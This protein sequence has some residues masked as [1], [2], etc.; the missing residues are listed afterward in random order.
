MPDF[1]RSTVDALK[2][3]SRPVLGRGVPAG[4]LQ[5]LID[6]GIT[7]REIADK[8]ETLLS[9][10][11]LPAELLAF[12][13]SWRLLTTRKGLP[14]NTSVPNPRRPR[15]CPGRRAR[16]Q[17]AARYARAARWWASP[18]PLARGGPARARA[19]HGHRQPEASGPLKAGAN[20][21]PTRAGP[22]SAIYANGKI[23]VRLK[24]DSSYS[25]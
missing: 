25:M 10:M 11:R 15:T 3:A 22:E 13:G 8:P 9:M 14:M 20:A 2:R 6:A 7:Q 18:V 23:V 24:G 21:L 5:R 19:C 1:G 12:A 16:T 17:Q 4:H